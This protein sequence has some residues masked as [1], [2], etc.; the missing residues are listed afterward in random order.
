VDDPGSSINRKLTKREHGDLNGK[1]FVYYH[2]EIIQSDSKL[3]FNYPFIDH[4]NT[5]NNSESQFTYAHIVYACSHG[6]E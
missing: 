5:D 1:I 4:G 3:L 2:F 6:K